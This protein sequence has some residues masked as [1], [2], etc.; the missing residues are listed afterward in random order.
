LNSLPAPQLGGIAGSFPARYPAE[1]PARLAIAAA[2]LA[3]QI[4]ARNAPPSAPVATTDRLF[5]T[6]AYT[7]DGAGGVEDKLAEGVLAY[8]DDALLYLDS[9]PKSLQ[10]ARLIRTANEDRKYWAND[11]IVAT[12]GRDLDF[13]VAHDD[14]APRPKW[15]AQYQ[16]NGDSVEVKGRKLTLYVQR[17]KQG[18]SV[19][20][21][22][23]V[24]QGKKSGS[25]LNLILFARPAG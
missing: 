18:T 10:G 21:S 25:A 2:A 15:L 4:T 22:G 16:P 1:L 23:N 17:L 8:S 5:S 12:A 11:Y 13:F 7:G 9:V 20:I 19:R 14:A 6:F 24:D 3:D